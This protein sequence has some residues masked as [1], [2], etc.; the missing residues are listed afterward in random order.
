MSS[1]KFISLIRRWFFWWKRT[2]TP[3][4]PP[5]GEKKEDISTAPTSNV[6]MY[7]VYPQID[8]RADEEKNLDI[9]PVEITEPAE[10]ILTI[11]EKAP[12]EPDKAKKKVKKNP[13]PQVDKKGFRVITDKHNLYALFGEE[14]VKQEPE[15][16]TQMFERAQTDSFQLR[17]LADKK[18]TKDYEPFRPPTAQ[19]KVYPPPQRELDLHGYTAAEAENEVESFIRNARLQGVRTLRVIVGKGLHSQG[20][21]VLPDLVERRIIEL[22]RLNCVL[23]FSWEKK[24]KTKSGAMIIY[25]VPLK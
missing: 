1:T 21:A 2:E 11:L 14:E 19:I 9:F 7:P 4:S 15:D 20:K 25:L 3:M 18:Q 17:L 16:F 10:P 23:G 13:E 8:I 6:A 12:A 24:E 5:I 22:K